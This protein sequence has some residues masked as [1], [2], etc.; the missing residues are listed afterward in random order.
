MQG[1]YKDDNGSLIWSADRVINDN[2]E[3]WIDQKDSY[4][5][6]VEGWHWFDSEVEAR[7]TLQCYGPQPFP[8]WTV[9]L[10][11]AEY[12]APVLLPDDGQFYSWNE[13]EL[14]WVLVPE[15]LQSEPTE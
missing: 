9:N 14:Q 12:Q 5:Y 13:E 6:P 7:N 8:S 11:T 1:F 3:L 4:E 2:F 10:E 15:I